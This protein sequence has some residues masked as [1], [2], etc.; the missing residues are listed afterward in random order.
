MISL[1]KSSDVIKKIDEQA[2]DDEDDEQADDDDDDEHNDDEN[3]QE[4]D[5][6][7]DDDEKLTTHDDEI[8]HEEDSDEDN[9]SISSSD[10]EDSDDEDE[11]KNVDGAKTQEEATDTED[12]G[13]EESSSV[14]SG[15]VSNMLNPNQDTGV[16]D[17]FRQNTEATSFIDTNITAIMEPS[18]TAQINR[19]PTPHPIIIQPQQQPILTPATTTSSSYKIFPTL[20]QFEKSLLLPN[21][22]FLET[23]DDGMKKIIK[24]QVKKEVSKI[25]PKVEKFVNDRLESEVLVRSSKEANSSHA[26]A[27]NL[28]ELELKKILIDKMEN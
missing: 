27:A 4:D 3:A 24:E 7:H 19:P 16:D 26:V 9:A 11:G 28:S 15:F 12:Q 5:D 2:E 1:G 8:I 22:Q 6:E 18:F 21:Q 13:N 20:P 14:S 23:I 10:D 17:I 25:I